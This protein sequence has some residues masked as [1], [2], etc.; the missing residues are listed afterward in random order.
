MRFPLTPLVVSLMLFAFSAVQA[1]DPTRFASVIDDLPLMSE[2]VEV[3]DGVEFST[4]AGRLAEV[5]A[6][7]QVSRKDV[8]SFYGATLPQLGWARVGETEFVREDESLTLIFEQVS[9]GVRVRF[10]LAPL[11]K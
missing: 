6:E 5:S 10:A 3:G 9:S 2:I 4:P 7:G 11:K 1:A 8:L